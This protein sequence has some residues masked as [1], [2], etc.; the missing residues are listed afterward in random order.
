MSV[1]RPAV[2]G[3][4]LV[5]MGI[6]DVFIKEITGAYFTGGTTLTE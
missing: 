2:D 5:G 4:V 3:I 1:L 6:N